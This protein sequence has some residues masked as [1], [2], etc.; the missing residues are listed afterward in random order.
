MKGS[1]LEGL[2]STQSAEGS[3]LNIQH[4]NFL[5]TANFILITISYFIIFTTA[6]IILHE[7][8]NAIYRDSIEKNQML[9]PDPHQLCRYEKC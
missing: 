1:D 6:N 9:R 7:T 2:I 8:K 3:R 4:F 5:T